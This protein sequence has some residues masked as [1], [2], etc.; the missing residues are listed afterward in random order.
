MEPSVFL[1]AAAYP[2]IDELCVV[3]TTI[4]CCGLMAKGS[5]NSKQNKN[6]QKK[7]INVVEQ[8]NKVFPLSC[9]SVL[10]SVVF[11]CWSAVQRDLNFTPWHSYKEN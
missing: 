1:Q 9:E 8:D 11:E 7:L 3:P 10:I 5:I 2:Q 4:R 6:K